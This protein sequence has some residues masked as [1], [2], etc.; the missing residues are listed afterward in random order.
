M[1]AEPGA[2]PDKYV[3]ALKYH[4]LTPLYDPA[5]RLFMR[6]EVFKGEIVRQMGLGGGQAALDIGCGTG[7]LLIAMKRACPDAMVVGIDGDAA[8]LSYARVKGL[9]TGSRL[10]LQVALAS[11][12]PYAGRTFDGI[13]S[14]LV[15][16]HLTRGDRA[17]AL[18]EAFRVLRPGGKIIVADFGVPR[19]LL[20]RAIS[21]AAGL[22]EDTRDNLAGLIPQMMARA[23]FVNV[24]ESAVFG[25]PF[26]SLSIYRG[27]RP[28]AGA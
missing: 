24:E 8:V 11:H 5:M 7:T 2:R 20:M 12:L 3:P 27:E 25:T 16:H 4:A 6:E 28:A 10:D 26:G 21:K 19:G 9:R 13:A 23:G 22:L 15:F 17:R 1:S 18:S 14:S